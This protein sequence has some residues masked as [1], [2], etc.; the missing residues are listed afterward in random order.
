MSVEASYTDLLLKLKELQEQGKAQEMNCPPHLFKAVHT[1]QTIWKIFCE[2]CGES[3][4][5]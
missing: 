2:K 5:L 4:S 3:R 1:Y